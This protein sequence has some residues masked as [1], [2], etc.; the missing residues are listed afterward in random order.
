MKRREFADEIIEAV[1]GNLAVLFHCILLL[2]SG[3][4]ALPFIA[5]DIFITELTLIKAFS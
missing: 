2:P 4:W 1:P 3:M 5:C